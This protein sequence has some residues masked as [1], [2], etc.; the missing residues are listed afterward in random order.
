MATDK[1]YT[2]TVELEP[3]EILVLTTVIKV[4]RTVSEILDM[5]VPNEMRARL[6]TVLSKLTVELN[7]VLGGDN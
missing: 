5:R 3:E 4:F 6:I 1:K 2:V 7:E